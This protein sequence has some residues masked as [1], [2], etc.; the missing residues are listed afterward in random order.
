[1]L[2]A[3]AASFAS[4][5]AQQPNIGTTRPAAPVASSVPSARTSSVAAAAS[6][7]LVPIFQGLGTTVTAP[8][9]LEKKSA[10]SNSERSFIQS[11]SIASPLTDATSLLLASASAVSSQPAFSQLVT[12]HESA[13]DKRGISVLSG[14]S[15]AAGTTNDKKSIDMNATL[16]MPS[17]IANSGTNPLVAK[18]SADV[19]ILLGTNNDFHEA[20]DHVLHVAEL[21]NLSATSNPLRVA[22]EIQTPPGAIVSVY[23]SRQA[24]SSYRAQLSTDDVQALSWVQDQ[25]GSLKSATNTG[26][27]IRWAPAQLETGTTTADTASSSNGGNL[28]WNRGGNQDSNQS[29]DERPAR[30]R[31]TFAHDDEDDLGMPFLQTLGAMGSAA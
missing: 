4:S 20:I 29:P 12:T 8:A 21:S 11:P 14:A 26:T 23:V 19:H 18:T 9:P 7:S 1:M 25:I 6:V 5:V 13:P 24:D 31:P 2:L 16:E 27:D 22:I 15:A 30:H 17:M 3:Q 10:G 28:D